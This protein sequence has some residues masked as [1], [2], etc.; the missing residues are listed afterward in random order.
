MES[1]WTRDRTHVSCIG[2]WVLNHWTTSEAQALGFHMN[3]RGTSIPSVR[4]PITPFPASGP[5]ADSSLKHASLRTFAL[6]VARLSSSSMSCPLC[7]PR[8]C[9]LWSHLA[10]PPLRHAGPAHLNMAAHHCCLS[11]H[12]LR[13]FCAVS[14]LTLFPGVFLHHLSPPKHSVN[15]RSERV[16]ILI[17]SVLH[18][19]C[20]AKYL[21]YQQN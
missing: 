8:W 12:R 6:P 10:R 18:A 1:S 17:C 20:P 15:I 2:R 5:L 19:P 14:P 13:F 11:L 7:S 9:G 3:Y 4:S 21:A 16:R